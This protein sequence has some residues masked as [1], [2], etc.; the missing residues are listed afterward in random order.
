MR[1]K[2]NVL[3]TW[4]HAPPR[5]LHDQQARLVLYG[6]EGLRAGWRLLVFALLLALSTH[7]FER[8]FRYQLFHLMSWLTGF[9]PQRSVDSPERVIIG[10]WS[11][12]LLLAIACWAMSMVEGR[13]LG[14]YGLALRWN[15]MPRLAEGCALGLVT[16]AAVLAS[17]W[18]VHALTFGSVVMQG[19]AAMK[20]GALWGIA[21]LGVGLNEEYLFRG[22]LQQTMTRGI[23]FWPTAV[24]LSG[25]F[26]W[27]HTGNNGETVQGIVAVFCYG[28]AFAF[29][30]HRSGS[31]WIAVGFHAAFDW[32]Q[33][34]LFGVPDSG[35]VTTTRLLAPSIHASNWITGGTAGPE[36]SFPAFLMLA[37]IAGY[38]VW[39]FPVRNASPASY[40]RS[41]PSRNP[42]KQ[43]GLGLPESQSIQE[44]RSS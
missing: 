24:A 39:R 8:P 23:G 29:L 42:D 9:H 27:F 30:V 13:K 43:R 18:S 6:P 14:A 21:F 44:S 4:T 31:L 40:T 41:L 20:G 2:S 10:H 32:G 17:L 37:L 33:T 16:I 1:L 28:L 26:A 35:S 38:A 34:F 22:F 15:S 36:A 3:S 7:L 5:W 19:A 11:H 12:F 25:A